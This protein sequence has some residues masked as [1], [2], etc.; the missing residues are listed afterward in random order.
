MVPCRACGA[1]N[2]SGS[3]TCSECGAPLAV[4]AIPKKTSTSITG[5]LAELQVLEDCFSVCVEKSRVG[6]AVVSGEAGMGTSTLLKAFASRLTGRIPARRIIFVNHIE[7]G[8]MFS[9]MRRAILQWLDLDTDDEPV[10]RRLQLTKHV[11][12]VLG[13]DS[14]SL[15]TETTHL[16]GFLTGVSFPDSPVLKSLEAN[17]ELMQQRIRE[18]IVRFLEA[19]V[20]KNPAVLIFDDMQRVN[21]EARRFTI[22]L[23]NEFSPVPFFVVAGGRPEVNDV[24]ENKSVVRIGL[25]P[26]DDEMMGGMFQLFMSKLT[27]PPQ[28]LIDTTVGRALGNPGSLNQLCALLKESGV[29]DTT[30]EPWTTD[31]SKLAT[32]E[33][34][35]N[36][37]EAL[38]ARIEQLDLRDKLVLKHAAVFGETFWDE[39][40]ISL[41]RLRTR[42]KENIGA[43]QI[44]ADESDCLTVGSSLDRLVERQFVTQLP[45]S[46]V[47][48]CIKYA[49][50]RQGIRKSIIAD[51]DKKELKQCHFLAAE[52][53]N[54]TTSK[55]GPVFFE[56]E[57]IHWRAAGEKHRAAL[58]CFEAARHARTIHLN[59][60]AVK[61]FKKGLQFVNNENRIVIVDALHDLG[62]VYDLLGFYDD[63]EKCFTQM[64]RH[65]WILTH[66]GKAGAALNRIS[67]IYRAKGDVEAARAFLNRG[68]TL[69]KAAGDEKGVAACLGDLGELA[70][71]QGSYDRAFKLVN[72]ALDLQRKLENKPSIG[73]CL[74]RLGHIEAAR[75][76]YTQ[77]ER[78]LEEALALRREINDMGGTAQTLSALAFVLFNRGD[79]DAAITRW[80]AALGL[81]EAVGDRRMVAII[82][83]NLGEALRSQGKLD[84]SMQYFKSCEE[85]VTALDDRLLH[86]EVTRNM[87]ILAQKMG[88]LVSAR[89]YLDTALDLAK[90]ISNREREGLA[91]RALG[92]LESTTMWDTSNVGGEDKAEV[93]FGKALSIFEST[94]NAYEMA[95]TLHSLGNRR[96]ERGDIKGGKEILEKAKN[97]YQRV[98]SKAGDQIVRTIQEIVG[99]TTPEPPAP[100]KPPGKKKKK[101]ARQSVASLS[102]RVR[103]RK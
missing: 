93:S 9:P 96:L 27:D 31:L 57:A 76:S 22:D 40:I 15:V 85:V 80:E 24:T 91:H 33:E 6:G 98:E 58:A 97:L 1:S 102:A 94:G 79:L 16:L 18:V 28:E 101:S 83:N 103:K 72:E 43:A 19:D 92:E 4:K 53:L 23:L 87:G 90:S 17:Q 45:E 36:L 21:F 32:T 30:T 60:K 42:L 14:A 74:H 2:I 26:L 3:S 5:R 51:M 44:W 82:N 48:G 70:G 65:A 10:A 39:A 37:L 7:Q 11:S 52:W 38:Q 78:Y 34:P 41:T 88:D 63:A 35:V 71:R 56:R 84:L 99:Q 25:E 100:K 69:F 13:P 59:Q 86:S 55:P 64:L 75:A 47:A 66:R 12:K 95:R 20:Q 73:V 68:M 29:V 49:F 77:A 62:S 54:H 8:D 50:S 89:Q 61:L 81:S 46:D 67:R